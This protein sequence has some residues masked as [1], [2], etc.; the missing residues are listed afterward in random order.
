MIIKYDNIEVGRH[1]FD[2]FV[3]D[4][5]VIELNVIKDLE[6][7]HFA[8]VKSYLKSVGKKQGLL[9]NFAKVK[10]EIKR[11]IYDEQLKNNYKDARN[12]GE[13][14]QNSLNNY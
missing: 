4:A 3:E 5:I 2:L 7:I 1:R 9:L 13:K 10:R 14:Q 12:A 11:V 6:D 8:I